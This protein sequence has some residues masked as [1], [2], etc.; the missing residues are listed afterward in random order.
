MGR[1]AG[2]ARNGI[3]SLSVL[4]LV[5]V[6]APA[7]PSGPTSGHA[8]PAGGTWGR[9]TIAGAS[10]T[11]VSCPVAG[12]CVAG[13]SS[14]GRH[15]IV[16]KEVGSHWRA[17][18][19]VPGIGSLDAGR[20]SEVLAV[21]CSAPGSC[22]AVGEY[23]GSQGLGGFVTNEVAG[24]WTTAV[25]VSGAGPLDTVSCVAS[26]TCSAAGQSPHETNSLAAGPT[27]AAVVVDETAGVWGAAMDVPGLP[28]ADPNPSHAEPGGNVTSI[29]CPSAGECSAGGYY[30][31]GVSEAFVVSESSGIWG[32]AVILNPYDSADVVTSVSCAAAGDC[33][34]GGSYQGRAFVIDELHHLWGPVVELPEGSVVLAVS[35]VPSGY[36][37]AGGTTN[38]RWAPAFVV[39]RRHGLWGAAK[40]GAPTLRGAID[41]ISCAEP[42]D[43]SAGEQYRGP[44][45]T[46]RYGVVVNEMAGVWGPPIE[47][48]GTQPVPSAQVG[49]YTGASAVSCAAPGSCSAVGQF[50]GPKSAPTGFVANET[51]QVAP[52]V[53]S[54]TP[55]RG[56]ATGGTRVTVLGDGFANAL[57]VRFGATPGTDLHVVDAWELTV[58]APPGGAAV[59]VQV[60]TEA[61]TSPTV[62]RGTFAYLP[63]VERV[64]PASGSARGGR[65]VDV[66]GAGFD[67]A[68]SVR[69]GTRAAPNVDVVS[70]HDV[71]VTV[72]AGAGTVDVR[73]T[74]PTGTSAAGT[75]D[76]YRYV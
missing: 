53:A 45:P 72:P 30:E 22:A 37:A 71:R 7:A 19:L 12:A 49:S 48:A 43:C 40:L 21:S 74:T 29:S 65:R 51:P 4:A 36:C 6:A 35:C 38:Y 63:V 13:G 8:V 41:A 24:T 64:A 20:G 69:F 54:I 60:V 23:L 75:Q 47:V 44:Q 66:Y 76:R 26:G 73:V 50:L 28:P 3:A 11:S 5:G 10:L 68:T 58:V 27:P 18:T 59:G 55:S 17:P 34:A 67:G 16:A 32:T 46:P 52:K 25:A 15:A 39:D 33:S 42:G 14:Q 56:A 70:S 9:A 57:S 1:W 31:N 62:A 2:S 61:G